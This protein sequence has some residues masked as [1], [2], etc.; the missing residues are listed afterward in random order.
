MKWYV[1]MAA[2]F[3][4]VLL[5]IGSL[6]APTEEEQRRVLFAQIQQAAN[7]IQQ[8]LDQQ[9]Q[10]LADQGHQLAELR[11]RSEQLRGQSR[12]LRQQTQ[13]LPRSLIGQFPAHMMQ[14]LAQARTAIVGRGQSQNNPAQV[15]Q[16]PSE[17]DSP[18]NKFIKSLSVELMV[19][20]GFYMYDK[21]GRC[22]NNSAHAAT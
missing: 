11:M 3:G 5:N 10:Q 17:K 12:Q 16:E 7:G 13:Q 8:L 21:Y 19:F 6:M 22:K 1:R 9:G 14:M 4:M 20:C 2:V 18:A 15:E